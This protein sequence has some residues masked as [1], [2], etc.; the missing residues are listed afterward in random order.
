MPRRKVAVLFERLGPYHVARIRAC[1]RYFDP[2]G[3]EFYGRDSIYAW[4][5][6]DGEVGFDRRTVLPA[7]VTDVRTVIEGVSVALKSMEVDVVAVPGWSHPGAL[8]AMQWCARSAVPFVLMADSFETASRGK[9]VRRWVKRRLVKM[10]GAALV[11]GTVHQRFLAN[12]GLQDRLIF[13]G[14]DVVDN[15][16][17]ARRPVAL[18]PGWNANPYLL[19][20]C[21]FIPEKNL[22]FLLE[23]YAEFAS[24]N[25]EIRLP[26]VIVGD[27]PERGILEDRIRSLS[28]ERH[29]RMPGFQQYDD[30]PAIY[31]GARAFILPS[32]FEPWGLVV[33]EAM[34]AGLPVLVS[35][36]CGCAP[37][38]VRDGVN[39]F[40]F[41]PRDQHGLARLIGA[42]SRSETTAKSM[43]AAGRTMIEA[44]SPDMFGRSLSLAVDAALGG[45]QRGVGLLEK[46]TLDAL[47]QV[48]KMS[49]RYKP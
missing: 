44:W 3:L 43:G 23:A 48:T 25:P 28:L 17:F 36:R 26:L 2:V 11:A 41:D 49:G 40:T 24:V 12:L 13:T 39:G 27:G 21:R 33:N 32:M 16:H 30:L 29:V 34:A 6:V 20:V 38:L 37:D 4:D 7:Q 9:A 18:D 5:P 45:S 15:E 35:N 47:V 14:Y 42:I 19:T 8:A 31:A 22:G 10:A 1:M 46:L